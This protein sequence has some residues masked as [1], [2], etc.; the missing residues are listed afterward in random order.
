M[1]HVI[2]KMQIKTTMR[3]HYTLLSPHASEVAEQQEFSHS[4]GGNTE[5][6][7]TLGDSLTVS[8]KTKRTPTI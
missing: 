2:R 6:T 4:A 3:C 7:T 8:Y 5:W 1:S